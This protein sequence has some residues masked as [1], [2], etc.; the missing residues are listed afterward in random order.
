LNGGNGKKNE[1][2]WHLKPESVNC[3]A[4]EKKKAI[5]FLAA[6]STKVTGGLWAHTHPVSEIRRRPIRYEW[7]L[8]SRGIND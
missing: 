4:K 2:F 1:Y 8:S 6:I 3:S 7:C 5:D